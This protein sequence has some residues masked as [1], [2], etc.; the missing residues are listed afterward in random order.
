MSNK[1]H[2]KRKS[3]QTGWMN[4]AFL[5]KKVHEKKKKECVK[6]RKINRKKIRKK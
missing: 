4:G 3:K 1:M 6:M 5:F 2:R